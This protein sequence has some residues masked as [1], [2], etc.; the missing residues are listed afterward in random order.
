MSDPTARELEV[1]AAFVRHRS[2][3]CAAA[4]LG[5]CDSTAA[6]HLRRLYARLGVHTRDEAAV[7]IDILHASAHNPGVKRAAN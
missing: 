1:L 3:K 6:V 5:I 2:R 7:S 4:E